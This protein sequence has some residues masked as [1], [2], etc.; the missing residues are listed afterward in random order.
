MNSVY[1]WAGTLCAV[2]I[3]ASFVRIIAPGERTM[4]TISLVLGVF[5]VLAVTSPLV[6]FARNLDLSDSTEELFSVEGE[7]SE[8]YNQ[9]VIKETGDYLT[10]YVF[11]LLKTSKISPKNIEVV[12]GTDEERGIYIAACRI[13]MDK[14]DY[15]KEEDVK[16]LISSSLAVEPSIVYE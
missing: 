7:A 4:K 16:E 3:I 12:M 9:E 6:N 5:V 13:Y 2:L 1:A 8:R 14:D 10:A 15:Q 11:E